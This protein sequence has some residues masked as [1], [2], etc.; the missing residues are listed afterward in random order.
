MIGSL[1]EDQ[2]RLPLETP[3]IAF[4]IDGVISLIFHSL[5]FY[6]TQTSL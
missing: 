4:P 3:A 2:S 1:L 5:I 6:D